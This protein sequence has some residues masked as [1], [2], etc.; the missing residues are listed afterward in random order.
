MI[1]G[2]PWLRLLEWF[3]VD[4]CA[5]LYLRIPGK[6]VVSKCQHQAGPCLM[7]DDV[8]L[9]VTPSP[10]TVFIVA[11]SVSCFQLRKDMI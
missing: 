8:V 4:E 11:I 1:L 10:G 3:R 6:C 7:R 9:V 5:T 2:G